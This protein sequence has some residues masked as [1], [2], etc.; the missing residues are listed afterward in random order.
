MSPK[1]KPEATMNL[2]T[3][4]PQITYIGWA[5]LICD[6][7]VTL[8][9][10]FIVSN[11]AKEEALG[12]FHFRG[13]EIEIEIMERLT[14]YEQVLRG[15]V[16]L[17]EASRNEIDRHTFKTYVDTLNIEERYRGIQGIG[18]AIPVPANEKDAHIREV[19]ISG[20]P[21]YTIKPEGAREE[22][23]SILYLEPFSGRNLR[24]F[25]YDMYSEPVRRQAMMRAR[26][27]GKPSLSGRVTLVQET[28]EDIQTGFLI[29]I[30]AY[31]KEMPVS[32]V[33]QRRTAFLG[34]VYSPFRT[35]DFLEGVLGA[36]KIPDL[37]FRLFDID[38]KGGKSLLYDSNPEHDTAAS[39]FHKNLK[40]EFDDRLWSLELSSLKPFE[41]TIEKD[42]SIAVLIAGV[43]VSLVFFAV[44]WLTHTASKRALNY[45]RQV[46]ANLIVS[47]RRL[48][49]IL[50]LSPALIYIK[51]LSG[52]YTF[53]NK[54]LEEL[55][56]L[57]KEA[58]AGKTTHDVYP[59]PIADQFVINDKRVMESLAPQEVEEF[60]MQ[61]DGSF[62]DFLS[63]QFPLFDSD[64]K[65]YAICGIS[66]DITERKAAEDKILKYQENLEALVLERTREMQ[67]TLKEL[68]KSE[69]R[70]QLTFEATSEGVWD[71]DI[72]TGEVFYSS[73]WF[74]LLGYEPGELPGRVD[75]WK[76]RLHRDDLPEV[77]EKLNAHLEGRTDSYECVNRLKT[78]SGGWQWNLD[79]GKV[80]ERDAEGKPVRMVGSDSDITQIKRAEADLLENREKFRLLYNQ[81]S[82]VLEGTSSA[83]SGETFFQSLVYHLA[84]TLGFS[85]C[86]I[87]RVDKKNRNFVHPLA[88]FKDGENT[89][90]PCYPLPGTPC[91]LIYEGA[92]VY[93]MDDLQENFP[94]DHYLKEHG[95]KSYFGVPIFGQNGFPVAH[96]VVM[97]R[98]PMPYSPEVM[99]ILSLFGAR[100]EAELTR[101]EI[102]KELENRESELRRAQE[103][104]HMGNWTWD[105]QQEQLSWSDEMYRIFGL[106]PK[107]V[108]LT[109]ADYMSRVHPQDR[110]YVHRE[111][112]RSHSGKP[113]HDIE[114][115]I[116]LPNGI[117]KHVH[118]ISK[119]HYDADGCPQKLVGVTHD[120]SKIKQAEEALLK[121]REKFRLL[122]NQISK[123]LEG[124]S[125]ATSGEKFFQSLVYHLAS[126]LG[127]D[128]SFLALV[129]DSSIP[130]T[131]RTLAMYIDGENV[132]NQE[133]P[134][135]GTP[136]EIVIEGAAVFYLDRFEEHFQGVDKSIWKRGIESY[137]GVPLFDE[138]G[139]T[140]G[141]LVV[142]NSK[143]VEY[144][145]EVMFILSLFA[146]RAEAE[147][148]R[149]ATKRELEITGERLRELNKK[150]QSIREEEKL[151]LAREIHDELG[152]V[153]TYCKLDL[154]WIKEQID[155]PGEVIEK[156][157]ESMV[158]HLD[159]SLARVR[160]I[161][162]ELRPGILDVLGISEAI[163]WQAQK[164]EDQTDI[165]YEL[166]VIP[167][168]F[169]CDKGLSTDL[170]RI[171]Q[172]TLTNVTRHAQATAVK[173]NFEKNS[174]HYILS[175]QDN[176][177]GFDA[178]PAKQ[179]LSLGILGMKERALKWGGQVEIKS[180]PGTGSI[181]NVL[182]PTKG[183]HDCRTAE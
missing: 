19:R 158:S 167:E 127:F 70:L 50:D 33:D 8:G 86:F 46:N 145:P 122:Y 62:R 148:I 112:I 6:L 116:L 144:S 183:N 177:C 32:T 72:R 66:T 60:V 80:V 126:K 119:T 142:M 63:V 24:A 51:D 124:T 82:E 132:P 17:F 180:E 30:P 139:K 26:D 160:R 163:K 150:M 108:E 57:S 93:H 95:L 153:L 143:P 140:T 84:S 88:F 99:S 34:Y 11:D 28:D 2:N 162:S 45:A 12:R 71:W 104:A 44:L 155:D 59:K 91:E 14:A 68:R 109:Y 103:M 75:T 130:K 38:E 128:Y 172:E 136:C 74:K 47:E 43:V 131:F 87:G 137:L 114:Y 89:S 37:A 182:I 117:I 151:H 77:M 152:Q 123:V 121:N 42:K 175:V 10:W 176:G 16:G 170:F 67:R 179:S 20:F 15:V 169:E 79:R 133:F 56:G 7:V 18:F 181:I 113:F 159:E 118:Q 27:T 110:K 41:N 35:R 58:I 138:Q 115:R 154:L 156:K 125:S 101:I 48:R 65:P 147:L 166:Q 78:K 69:E 5:I 40:I 165:E 164:F 36:R 31:K 39:L 96:L 23:T 120:I 98:K 29:Y 168:K 149:I 49:N 106:Q 85:L 135:Q 9:L 129:D 73:Q 157:L 102:Q 21:E 76:S 173:I 1:A 178:T 97:D 171:F 54:K 4:L 22:Y 55:T 105:V 90:A 61:R 134:L 25:G 3:R 81:I 53:I 111:N 52:R 146:A 100:A 141:H 83:T 64:D 174:N 161:S 92:V 13:H 107:E 94:H